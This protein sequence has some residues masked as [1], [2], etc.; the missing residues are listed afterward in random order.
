MLSAAV[1]AALLLCNMEAFAQAPSDPVLRVKSP[2]AGDIWRA[3]VSADENYISVSSAYASVSTWALDVPDVPVIGRVPVRDE[4]R[5]RAHAIALHPSGDLIAYSV[6]P[7]TAERD[8]YRPGSGVI[9]LL[10][11]TTGEIVRRLGGPSDDIATRPQALRFSPDGQYLAAVL[12]SGCGLRVWSTSTWELLA[13][14]DIGYGGVPGQDLCCRSG[15]VE[16]CDRLPDG[17]ALSFYPDDQASGQQLVTSGD[18]GVRAYRLAGDRLDPR[19]LFASPGEIDLERPAGL[20]ISPDGGS[21]VVGDRRA[22]SAILPLRFR[23][24][25]LDRQTLQPRRAPLEVKESALASGA[26]LQGG[27][28]VLDLLQFTLDR[29]A[30]LSSRGTEHIF[31]GSL[32]CKIAARIPPGSAARDICLLRWTLGAGDENPEFIP[33]GIDR[34][35]DLIAL[36]KRQGILVASPKLIALLDESGAPLQSNIN[37]TFVQRNLAADLR[38]PQLAFNISPDAQVVRFETY[39]AAPRSHPP[40]TFDLRKV[41]QPLLADDTLATGAPNQDPNI[42]DGWRNSRALRIVGQPLPS[43]EI[44]K[45]EM[46]RAAA[47]LYDPKIVLLGSSELLRIVAYGDGKPVVAC[48]EPVTEEAFR[49]NITPDGTLVVSAHSD[50]TI[51]WHRI[52][53]AD[54]GCSFQLLLSVRFAQTVSGKLAW[55]AWRPDGRHAQDAAMREGLQWQT[56]DASGRVT[57]TPLE[58]LQSWYDP[59]AIKAALAAPVGKRTDVLDRD[60]VVRQAAHQPVIEVLGNP[61]SDRAET[62]AVRLGL[63]FNGI[64][65]QQRRL[66]V[67][68]NNTPVA[69]E[70]LN[71]RYEPG[72]DIPIIVQRLIQGRLELTVS[73]PLNART[74]PGD[75]QLCFYLNGERDRCHVMAWAGDLV[76]PTRRR[77]WAVFVGVSRYADPSLNLMFA[78]NDVLDLARLFVSDFE[79]RLRSPRRT[80]ASAD[81]QEVHINLAVSGSPQG[82]QDAGALAAKYPYVKRFGATRNEIFAAIKDIIAQRQANSDGL[83][84]GD[85]LFVFY[86]SGHGIISPTEK[87]QGRT[88]FATSQS[89]RDAALADNDPSTLDSLELLDLFEAMPGDKLIIFDACRSLSA[90]PETAAFDPN[91]LLNDLKTRAL[92]ADIFF[93]SD[94]RQ[95]SREVPGLAYDRSRPKNRQGNSLFTYGLLKA[96]TTDETILSGEHS[97]LV[98]V[99]VLG[100]A[101]YFDTVFF[102]ASIKDGEAARLMK[103]YGWTDIQTPRYY[104]AR[105]GKFSSV[106]RTFVGVPAGP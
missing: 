102:N 77:L 56:L 10:S 9:Y 82:E 53:W 31:A 96:L 86:F 33:V 61:R 88:L 54:R 89:R 106:V 49:V 40:T 78:D 43:D 69:V 22:P 25:I 75:F 99:R 68:V 48:R 4:E 58:R 37:R 85:D 59:E 14:D 76:K 8:T 67:R 73:L 38:E 1:S 35:R 11:R 47:V 19:V 24:A 12:S 62:P 100:L 32:P 95:P 44:R 36:N 84:L 74:L 65:D 103:Q 18:T 101:N 28:Q 29:V 51:R 41:P 66:S 7:L 87:D 83:D 15:S 26:F 71:E 60:R 20:A 34:V 3:D 79:Q 45:D 6:P 42:V 92:S 5:K 30:W 46:F 16:D 93:S 23:I 70:W 17:N 81:Y 72:Q 27:P 39:E 97:R 2:F 57:L 52:I 13:K 63:R 105:T 94:A 104:L 21:M 90:A 80:S 91:Y 50:G 98:S 64:T 55:I